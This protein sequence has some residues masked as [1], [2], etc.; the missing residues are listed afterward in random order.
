MVGLINLPVVAPY[1]LAT[2]FIM[3]PNGGLAVALSFFPLTAPVSMSIRIAM[4]VVPIWQMLLSSIILILSAVGAI[5]LSARAYR[6]GMVSYG[7]K[8]AFKELLG[9]PGGEACIKH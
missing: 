4:T 9:R 1:W 6:L 5:W 2:P 7:K 8:V 3:N